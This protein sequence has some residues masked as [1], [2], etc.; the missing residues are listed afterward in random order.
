MTGAAPSSDNFEPTRPT[1]QHATCVTAHD[2][3]VLIT[4]ASGSGKSSLALAL[5][6]LGAK[7]IADDRVIL[8]IE[9]GHIMAS[10]P[11]A[12]TGLIEAR[13]IGLLQAEA[14]PKA[15]I[16]LVIDLNQTE[17][18]R[19]PPI[20]HTSVMGLSVPLLYNVDTLHF[21]AAVMQYLACGRQSE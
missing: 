11:M 5:M 7:L 14:E 17:T 3:G 21:P 16:R 1:T 19:M 10:A 8:C 13:G 12:I 9:Q 4:G 15:S 18:E 6:G 2:K 20:R